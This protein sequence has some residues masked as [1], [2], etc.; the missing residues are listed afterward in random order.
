[1]Q[2]PAG[3]DLPHTRA[4]AVHWLTTAAVLAAATVVAAMIEPSG[5]T[6][7]ATASGERGPERGAAAPTPGPDAEAAEYP[8]DCGPLGVV[9]SDQASVDLDGDGTG[10]TVAVVHCDAGSGTPPHGVYL[11]GHGEGEGAAPRVTETLVDPA[12]R[13]NVD[14]FEA[15]DD[16]VALRLYGYSSPD[17]PSCCPDMQRDVS[18]S[19]RDGALT[20]DV[21]P[22]P[23]SV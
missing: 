6:A 22:P 4:R 15:D 14:R 20:L 16:A 2:L 8:L 12:E 23:N 7:T 13:M 9:V 10:E 19:W 21:A 3:Q 11:L 1:M 17:V 18:W 5:A